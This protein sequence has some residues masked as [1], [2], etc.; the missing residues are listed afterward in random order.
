MRKRGKKKEV[1]INL[2]NSNSKKK[3][4]NIKDI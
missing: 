3:Y 2:K 4:K 1:K